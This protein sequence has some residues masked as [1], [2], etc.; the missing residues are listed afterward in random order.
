MTRNAAE[1]TVTER[2][3]T[4]QETARAP[5]GRSA[6][7]ILFASDGS[8]HAEAAHQFL[9]VLE[10]P[11]GSALRLVTV[12]DAE[13]WQL[14]ESLRGAEH[15]WARR[16]QDHAAAELDREGVEISRAT[17]RGRP[18]YEVIAAAEEFGADLLVVGSP[19]LTGLEGFLLGSVA[20]NVAKHAGRP[21]LVARAPRNSVRKVVLAVDESQHAAHAADFAA[22]LPLPAAAEILVVNVVRPYD[23]YPGL[24]PDDPAGFRREV[25]AVRRRLRKTAEELVLGARARLESG[26]KRAASEVREGDPAT[27]ILKLAA[28]QEADLIVAG[29]RGIS[30][31]Q[32]LL[33]G[34]VADRLLKKA[35]CSLLIVH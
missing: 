2:L 28:E 18:A 29:A 30:V 16:I 14:P 31:I 15:E 27:E 23:P 9:K 5:I 26:G 13:T 4:S 7:R 34:S 22:R 24:V 1:S 6:L 35:P 12:L 25:E 21:A 17:P 33:V 10:L 11:A 20:R 19:A 8:P 32:G 3:Q